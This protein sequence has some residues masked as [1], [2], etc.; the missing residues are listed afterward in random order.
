M[1]EGK[2]KEAR[3]YGGPGRY[4]QGPDEIKKLYKVV[5]IYGKSAVAI[6]DPFFFKEYS[7]ML[8]EQFENNGLHL[9]TVAFKGECSPTELKRI[10]GFVDTLPEAPDAYIGLGS[11]KTCDITKAVAATCDKAMIIVPTA[12]STDAPTSTHSIMYEQDG[13]H[14]TMVHKKNPEFIVVDTNIII[15]SPLHMFVS[16]LGDALATYIESRASF[17]NNNVNNICGGSYRPTLA[18]LAIAKL[19]F[20][21]LMSKGREA[22]LAAKN[23]IRTQAFEDIA[24]A[25]TLLSGVGFENTGCSIAHGLQTAFHAVPMKPWLHGAGVGY[26]TLAQLIVENRDHAEFEEIF[27]WCRDVG[28]PVCTSE[29]GIEGDINTQIDVLATIAMEKMWIMRNEPFTVTKDMLVNAI[30]Y[31]DAYAAHNK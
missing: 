9:Y 26:G 28:I 16:G 12:I 7:V 24:E 31:L 1:P 20:D 22:Y 27:S 6:I 11:G 13:T 14:F 23:H 8:Q 10:T 3:A 18:G 19:S 5:S 17:A 21:V 15:N 30:L 25:N 2:A 4:L 29:L